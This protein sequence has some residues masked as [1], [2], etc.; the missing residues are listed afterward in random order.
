MPINPVLKFLLAA[1]NLVKNQG[2]SK[3]QVLKFAKQEFGEVNELLKR[4]IDNL[5]PKGGIP[6]LKGD[7]DTALKNQKIKNVHN[8]F[9][10]KS[11]KMKQEGK[12]IVK[13]GLAGLEK[14]KKGRVWDFNE[15][16]DYKTYDDITKKMWD[17]RRFQGADLKEVT[18]E[19]VGE[20]ARKNTFG[21]K[22]YYLNELKLSYPNAYKRLSG[23]ESIAELKEMILRLDDEGIPFASGGVAY[24]LGEDKPRKGLMY[25][26][27]PGFAFEYGGSWAD[28]HDQHR[29]Q[30]PVEQYIKTKLPKDRLPFREDI[31]SQQPERRLYAEGKKGKLSRRGFLKLMGGLG[32]LPFVGKF[33]KLAKV[34]TPATEVAE[35]VA[36]AGSGTGMPAWFPSLIKRVI[37][38]GEDITDKAGAMERQTVHIAKTPE[39]TPIQVTRDLVSEDII[40]DIGEQTKH[41]WPAGRHGQPTRLALHKGQWSEPTKGKKGI[42]T[43][44]EF[45]VEEAEF[46]GGHPENVKFE[47]T[48]DFKYGDHGSD[49]SEVEK[50]A[51]GKNKDKKI[52][53]K[54]RDVDNWAEGR[55]EVEAEDVE[56]ASG[57][58]ARLLGE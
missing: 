6:T 36:T 44:D 54:Q 46:T 14:K 18:E 5:F 35:T 29:D 45:R 49:F 27:D 38:E 19:T 52:I 26:G 12:D 32:A 31:G 57:G 10:D 51:I 21:T 13:E 40:V 53:G 17:K 47:E 41:G 39:G 4:Q 37:K 50:Y 15:I 56:F 42:K 20:F 55:A 33:F 28:W 3:E 30:M 23:E 58:L 24:L 34:A 22:D 9:F 1:R 43:K 11:G 25:G 8:R 2:L 7:Y 16:Q 48:V